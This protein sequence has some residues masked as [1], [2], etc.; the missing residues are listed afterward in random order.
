MGQNDVASIEATLTELEQRIMARLGRY[1]WAII[2]TVIAITLGAAT[3][4]YGLT[5]RVYSLEVWKADRAKPIESYYTDREV[6]AER[7]AKIETKLEEIYR[8]LQQ[9]D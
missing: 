5:G 1:A 9:R 8:L 3:Q 4:W 6:N 2:G 7:L